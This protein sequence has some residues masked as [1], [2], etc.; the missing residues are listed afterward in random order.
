MRLNPSV[1]AT[2][3]VSPPSLAPSF[4]LWFPESLLG[5]VISEKQPA[6][7]RYVSVTPSH[8]GPRCVVRLSQAA[9][10]NKQPFPVR[11]PA[12]SLTQI[13]ARS[14]SLSPQK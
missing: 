3:W 11:T 7:V 1:A 2:K 5:V 13:H 12:S 8:P 4:A 6:A 10:I 14:L 9:A